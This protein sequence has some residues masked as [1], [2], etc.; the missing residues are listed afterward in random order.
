M[1]SRSCGRYYTLLNP[2]K[3]PLV[4][5]VVVPNTGSEIWLM[6]DQMERIC[7]GFMR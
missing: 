4:G 2:I 6:A 7:S 5:A 3:D 1:R